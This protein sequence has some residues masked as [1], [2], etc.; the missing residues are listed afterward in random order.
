[1]IN[2]NGGGFYDEPRQSPNTQ[3]I[4]TDENSKVWLQ[5]PDSS[6]TPDYPATVSSSVSWLAFSALV[7]KLVRLTA[8]HVTLPVLLIIIGLLLLPLALLAYQK[9]RDDDGRFKVLFQSVLVV[10]GIVIGGL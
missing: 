9:A 7:F 1:M 6:T 4:V 2:N 10:A 8:L 5:A 3:H